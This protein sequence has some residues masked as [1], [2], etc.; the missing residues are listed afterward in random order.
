MSAIRQASPDNELRETVLRHIRKELDRD[1]A[2]IDV[3]VEGGLVTLIGSASSLADKNTAERAA[4]EVDEVLV[5]AD[6]IAVRAPHERPDTQIARDLLL[7]FRTHPGLPQDAIRATVADGEVTLEGVVHWQLQKLTA[8]SVTRN[9]RGVRRVRNLM[10]VK[11]AAPLSREA[12][13]TASRS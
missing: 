12:T 11:P 2:A 4:K 8:E 6:E 1:S 7:R 10:E 3:Q 13:T 9:L 5:I